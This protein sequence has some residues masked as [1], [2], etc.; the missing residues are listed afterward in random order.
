MIKASVMEAFSFWT[1]QFNKFFCENKKVE[2]CS[3]S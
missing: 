2:L 1:V 3:V